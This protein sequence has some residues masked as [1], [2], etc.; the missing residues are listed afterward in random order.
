MGC[1]D[2]T[3]SNHLAKRILCER[4]SVLLVERNRR[5]IISMKSFGS[6]T[7]LLSLF[8]TQLSNLTCIVAAVLK[9]NQT[10]INNNKQTCRMK[11]SREDHLQL[12]SYS[13]R[14]I[15]SLRCRVKIINISAFVKTIFLCEPR[16][17]LKPYENLYLI[18]TIFLVR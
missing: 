7:S 14:Y 4:K 9:T 3:S 18:Q 1:P 16:L 6:E 10:T 15:F 13:E 17:S 5:S 2:G 11:N 12:N 8:R